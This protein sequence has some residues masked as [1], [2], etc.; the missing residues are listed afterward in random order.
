MKSSEIETS[1]LLESLLLVNLILV[2][3]SKVGQTFFPSLHL[4]L[5]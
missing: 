1:F 4:Q 2:N 3:L 5:H